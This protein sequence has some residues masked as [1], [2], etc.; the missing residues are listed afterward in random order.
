MRL[1]DHYRAR[2]ICGTSLKQPQT[3]LSRRAPPTTIGPLNL[4]QGQV[5]STGSLLPDRVSPLTLHAPADNGTTIA[6]LLC[7]YNRPPRLPRLQ[8]AHPLISFIDDL[9]YPRYC[10]KTR[11]RCFFVLFRSL[12][13]LTSF[14]SRDKEVRKGDCVL[15]TKEVQNARSLCERTLLLASWI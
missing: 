9:R 1:A 3:G 2:L 6:R 13:P 15:A 8:E 12:T 11:R 10:E 5:K 14:I 7:D 4:R